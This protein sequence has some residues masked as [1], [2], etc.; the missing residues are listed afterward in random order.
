VFRR[1][2]LVLLLAL[3]VGAAATPPAYRWWR[4]PA[5]PRHGAGVQAVEQW[6]M[7]IRLASEEAGLSDPYL[8]AGLVFA[9]SRGDAD[10]VSSIGALGLCQLLPSTAEELGRKYGVSTEPMSPEDNLRLGARYLAEQVKRFDG[11]EDVAVLGYRLGPFRVKR[12]IGEQGKQT[13]LDGLR[14][15]SPSPWGYVEQVDAFRE[16]FRARAEAGEV[17]WGGR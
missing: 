14:A 3:L 12:L 6:A 2:L 15:K 1:P 7:P 10:A 13:Y 5:S 17:A 11:D 16:H 4:S 9:E 8:L